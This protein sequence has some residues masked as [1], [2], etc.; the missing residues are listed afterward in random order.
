ML[1]PEARVWEKRTKWGEEGTEQT[2]SV[3]EASSRRYLSTFKPKQETCNVEMLGSPSQN[4]VLK[5]VKSVDQ[6]PS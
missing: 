1:F 3:E 4:S 6:M 5:T 2:H